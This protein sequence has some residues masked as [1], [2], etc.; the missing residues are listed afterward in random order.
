[1]AIRCAQPGHPDPLPQLET[2]RSR[3]GL[4]HRPDDLVAQH[5]RQ[6]RL[7]KF[8]IQDVQ[9]GVADP[10]GADLEQHLSRPRRWYG[11]FDQV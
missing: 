11:E 8:A 3:P 6:L 7:V 9:V 2:L 5:Q 1:V 4:H 10:A